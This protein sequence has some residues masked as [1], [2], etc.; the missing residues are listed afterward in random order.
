MRADHRPEENAQRTW[1]SSKVKIKKERDQE[2][3]DVIGAKH[4]EVVDVIVGSTTIAAGRRRRLPDPVKVRTKNRGV[5]IAM[6]GRA[7]R[8]TV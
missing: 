5:I 2:I 3:E 6:F 1:D 8:I 4:N 7:K